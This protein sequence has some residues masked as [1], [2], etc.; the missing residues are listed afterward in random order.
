M[1][2]GRKLT[3]ATG[4]L[5]SHREIPVCHGQPVTGVR[6]SFHCKFEFATAATAEVSVGPT[7]QIRDLSVRSS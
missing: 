7:I 6:G 5:Q 2:S 4:H 3:N 1:E